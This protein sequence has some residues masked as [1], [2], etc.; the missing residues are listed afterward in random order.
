MAAAVESNDQNLLQGK[1]RFDSFD[2]P[3]AT[4]CVSVPGQRDP[5]CRGQSGST[6]ALNSGSVTPLSWRGTFLGE[7]FGQNSTNVEPTIV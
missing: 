5:H 1:R 2:G 4:Q 6:C 7:N 3:V